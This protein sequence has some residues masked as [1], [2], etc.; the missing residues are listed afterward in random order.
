[1]KIRDSGD[2]PWFFLQ[3]KV[4]PIYNLPQNSSIHPQ[5]PSGLS[6]VVLPKDM[7]YSDAIAWAQIK[8]EI[9]I[10]SSRWEIKKL[11]NWENS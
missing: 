3:P 2:F 9:S 5:S 11:K 8:I 6:S 1:M 4:H 10:L 7:S